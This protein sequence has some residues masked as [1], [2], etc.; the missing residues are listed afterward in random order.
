MENAQKRKPKRNTED[1]PKQR[2]RAVIGAETKV[3]WQA[4]T[5]KWKPQSSKLSERQKDQCLFGR[6]LGLE[7]ANCWFPCTLARPWFEVHPNV[8]ALHMVVDADLSLF[9]TIVFEPIR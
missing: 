3:W 7:E 4:G 8:P 1:D 2:Q 9:E 6:F 5:L